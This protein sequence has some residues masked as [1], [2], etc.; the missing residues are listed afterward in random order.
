MDHWEDP[1]S[2]FTTTMCLIWWF[3][4]CTRKLEIIVT[5]ILASFKVWGL[6]GKKMH[7]GEMYVWNIV[8]RKHLGKISG[9]IE[10]VYCKFKV[11]WNLP[12]RL[13]YKQNHLFAV[14]FFAARFHRSRLN[15]C[16]RSIYILFFLFILWFTTNNNIIANATSPKCFEINFYA[17]Y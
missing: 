13:K 15:K 12:G 10:M 17:I 8:M 1:V 6:F 5:F 7:L 2:G 3:L 4:S 11:V 16:V 9:S 14:L